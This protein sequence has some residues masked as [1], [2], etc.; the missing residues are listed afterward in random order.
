MSIQTSNHADVQLGVPLW[1]FITIVVCP[2]W[3]GRGDLTIGV[4][5]G[6]KTHFSDVRWWVY[7]GPNTGEERVCSDSTP[8][9]VNSV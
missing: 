2:V 5:I 8:G 4:Q 7:E 9:T 3:G 1:S 6:K